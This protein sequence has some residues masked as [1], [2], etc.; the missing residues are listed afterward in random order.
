MKQLG[1]L[2]AATALLATSTAAQDVD[3]PEAFDEPMALHPESMGDFHF[4]ISSASDLAQQYFDQG[5][6]LMY[7]FAKLDAAR[8]FHAAQQADP[9]CAICYWGEAWAW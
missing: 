9:D 1:L 3:Y 4:P 5:F 6:Q 8:S 7:A 2:L